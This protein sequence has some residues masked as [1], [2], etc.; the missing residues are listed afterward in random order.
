MATDIRKYQKHKS[1]AKHRGIDFNLSFDEWLDIWQQSGKYHLRG[2]GAGTYVMSRI[3]D[4]GPYAIG[5]VFINSNAQN[6][7]DAKNT[8]RRKGST[9]SEE[10]KKM[11]S[12]QRKG[13]SKSQDWKINIGLANKGKKKPPQIVECVHCKKQGALNNMKR[14]HFDNCRSKGIK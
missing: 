12:E 8:G 1:T 10:T 2:R 13:K 7:I 6:V 5:N 14:W 11:F 3:N 4:A 9:H